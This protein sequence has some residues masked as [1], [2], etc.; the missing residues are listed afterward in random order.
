MAQAHRETGRSPGPGDGDRGGPEGA[1]AGPDAAA[2]IARTLDGVGARLRDI[3]TRRGLTLAEVARRT[4][5][6]VSTVSRLESGRRRATLELLLP[7]AGVY[8]V[9]LDELVGAPRS[10][11]PRIHPR[12]VRRAGR[13]YLPLSG[14]ALGVEACKVVMPPRRAGERVVPRT[15]AG[16]EWAYVLSGTLE[17]HL[18]DDVLTI[19]AGEAV[20]F[21]TSRPHWLGSAGDEPVEL[22][23]LF[24]ADGHRIHVSGEPG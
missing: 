15:H 16:W 11:D 13:V 5:A 6:S 10:G 20:E 14:R 17:L 7:L 23:S 8:R 3:R 1:A 21:D 19:G 9:P 2:D 24:D 22:L 18:G 4:G 12:P